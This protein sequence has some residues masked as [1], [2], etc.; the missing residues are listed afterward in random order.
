MINSSFTS[1]TGNWSSALLR[2]AFFLALSVL[3]NA[4]VPP[5]RSWSQEDGGFVGGDRGEQEFPEGATLKLDP[6]LEMKLDRAEIKLE[7]GRVDLA[8][9]LWQYVLDKS[10]DT[11]MTRDGWVDST[12]NHKYRRYKSI[13]AEIERA[14]SNLPPEGLRIYRVTADAEAKEI[15]AAGAENREAALAEVVRRFFLSSIGDDA[16]YELA[17][18]QLDR[19]DF[20]GARRLL[21]KIIEE[22]PDPSIPREQVMLRLAVANARVGD[23]RSAEK[24]LEA[25]GSVTVPTELIAQVSEE[26]AEAGGGSPQAASAADGWPMRLGGPARNRAMKPLPPSATANTLTEWWEQ[27]EEFNPTAA[28]IQTKA[29]RRAS[30]GKRTAGCRRGTFSCTTGCCISRWPTAAPRGS[31]RSPAATPRPA[32]CAGSRARTTFSSIR[33]LSGWRTRT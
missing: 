13:A 15:L 31:N 26:I 9:V 30:A 6:D 14:V 21:S 32:R 5:A 23:L 18:R 20:V 25:A 33:S 10:S 12:F 24:A 8:V 11:V 3:A 16:A 28:T 22:H 4:V 1:R 17:C 27:R 19:Y 29:V 2:G 7:E